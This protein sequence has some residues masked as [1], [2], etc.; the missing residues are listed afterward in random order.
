[1][2]AI[3]GLGTMA[4]FSH[5]RIG[6]ESKSRKTASGYWKALI[7]LACA[8]FL[9]S[10][11]PLSAATPVTIG[12]KAL[13]ITP[14]GQEPSCQG[15]TMFLDYLGI[16]YDKL[17]AAEQILT[18]EA[19]TGTDQNP[20]YQAIFL[21]NDNLG[22]SDGAN[23]VSAFT[24][25]EWTILRNYEAKF[26]IRQVTYYTYP[27]P[28][29]GLSTPTAMDTTS[30]AYMV[31]LTAEGQKVFPY[32]KAD[33]KIPIRY[34]YTYLSD[35][36]DAS[37]ISL[38]QD[39]A[40]HD[41]VSIRS[42]GDG[43]QNLAITCD[44]WN[45]LL[46]SQLLSYGIINWAMRGV[47]LGE[48]AVYLMPQIDDIFMP[49]ELY[50]PA[51]KNINENRSYRISAKDMRAVETWQTNVRRLRNPSFEDLALVMVYNGEG[52]TVNGK[53]DLK[54]SLVL[55]FLLFKQGLYQWI[56]HTFA[57]PDLNVAT[58]S[59]E[60]LNDLNLNH[61]V[62]QSLYL[63]NYSK[64]NLVTGDV[65]GL[66]NDYAMK[67]I[68]DFGIKQLVSNTSIPGQGNP[69]P[70]AGILNAVQPTVLEVPRRPTNI[71]VPA[72]TPEEETGLYNKFYSE[73]FKHT[74]TYE[75]II[76]I[77][78]DH[79][80]SYMVTYDMDPLMFHQS[81]L[82]A[83]DGTH[84]L[85]GDLINAVIKKYSAYMNKPVLSPTMDKLAQ[86][87]TQQMTYKGAGVTAKWVPGYGI[88]LT[89]KVNCVVALSGVKYGYA[90]TVDTFK[91]GTYRLHGTQY[92]SYVSL[93]AGIPL[94]VPFTGGTLPGTTTLY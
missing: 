87:M 57:H 39:Q 3:N 63:T 62:A 53:L 22:Y 30:A 5:L 79:V 16:P 12:M 21:T 69:T 80:L 26:Q 33:A 58:N 18:A 83:Y 25:D 43:R 64:T 15:I 7:V 9:L 2:S 31:S 74:F 65:S 44:N 32:L 91:A 61:Q 60:V 72:S 73:Q 35:V 81:N 23:W 45:H 51:T 37:T 38:V 77:E 89:S 55:Y 93:R 82:R 42:Y 41:I 34:A 71:Y 36:T 8:A 6:I 92:T 49:N 56:S 67:G 59:A 88:Q 10:T 11:G 27:T 52:A 48:H 4:H 76:D 19:L 24:A 75:E 13:V 50:D 17:I 66:A 78:S 68:K 85:L 84:F 14:T 94:F 70:N 46:H 28:D 54:D 86:H 90:S 47:H 40:G 20:L 1:M 29:Y